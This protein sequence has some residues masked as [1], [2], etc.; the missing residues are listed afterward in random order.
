MKRITRTF[1]LPA[2][3]VER[4][5]RAA[6]Q[7]GVDRTTVIESAIVE[8]CERIEA[9][10]KPYFRRETKQM[11]DIR[12]FEHEGRTEYYS[13]SLFDIAEVIASEKRD[14]F[15]EKGKET[16]D[17]INPVYGVKEFLVT[18]YENGT[19]TGEIITGMEHIHEFFRK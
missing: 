13:R 3:L 6:A 19:V 12:K 9:G 7:A 2:S 16:F 17:R 11:K 14:E 1:R 8:F 15:I 4:F 5:D 10:E 18:V